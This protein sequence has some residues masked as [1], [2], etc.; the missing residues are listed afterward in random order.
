[1]RLYDAEHTRRML[2]IPALIEAL[3]AAAVDMADGRIRCPE[4]LV[5][6]LAGSGVLLSMPAVAD[7][8]S[9]HKLISVVPSNA[10]LGL[11]AIQ[12]HLTVLE[13]ATGTLRMLL[14]G[15]TVTGRRTA[16]MSLLGMR[17][18]HP[19]RPQHVLL[20]GAGTQAMHHLDALAVMYPGLRVTVKARSAASAARLVAAY[21]DCGLDLRSGQEGGEDHGGSESQSV[22][23]PGV[24]GTVTH[25]S[26][27]AALRESSAATAPPVPEDIDV[28]IT[29]T[30]SREPVYAEPACAA[31]L[32]IAVGAFQPQAAE[33]DAVTVRA[34]RIVVDDPAGARHE[35]GDLIRAGVAWNDVVGLH[36]L[37]RQVAG[38]GGVS[39][40]VLATAAASASAPAAATGRPLL[41]K[42]V[43]CAAWDLAAARLAMQSAG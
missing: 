14:D 20:I 35:A 3:A 10:P 30:T 31:R 4:R 1:M 16:A 12:G 39:S 19:G 36:T 25:A 18:L 15:P 22:S 24:S 32:I 42:S 5:V 9:V 17:T 43:G 41:F 38:T 21:A 2:P 37:L 40:A 26:Q 33:I 29:C 28:V 6:P 34:S 23:H 7:D 11:P 27:N 8:I 13:T